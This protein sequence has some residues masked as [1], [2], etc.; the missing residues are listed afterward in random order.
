MDHI[1]LMNSKTKPFKVGSHRFLDFTPP[2]PDTYQ[3]SYSDYVSSIFKQEQWMASG[4]QTA[5]AL[6]RKTVSY[7]F[8]KQGGNNFE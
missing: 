2:A 5:G 4:T 6:N 8:D 7:I 1:E 3:S